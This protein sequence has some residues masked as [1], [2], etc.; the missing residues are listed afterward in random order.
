[1]YIWNEEKMRALF[2]AYE[3]CEPGDLLVERT[4]RLMR[5]E[6]ACQTA[7]VP[8]RLHGWMGALLGIALLLALNLFYALTVGTLLRFTLPPEWM[9]ILTRSMFICAAAGICMIAGTLL[10]VV[11]TQLRPAYARGRFAA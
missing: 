8:V 1:M 2:R 10:I 4:K 9:H 5:A 11:F 7:P 3:V 6:L